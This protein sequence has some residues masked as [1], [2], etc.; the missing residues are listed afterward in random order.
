MDGRSWFDQR[1]Q[2]YRVLEIVGHEEIL[3]VA[4]A[5][6]VVACDQLECFC[7]G[8]WSGNKNRRRGEGAEVG[9]EGRGTE[10]TNGEKRMSE[11]HSA[12][13]LRHLLAAHSPQASSSVETVDKTTVESERDSESEA[14]TFTRS[15]AVS[16]VDCM[17]RQT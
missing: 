2:T 8:V 13:Y 9:M 11:I 3:Q 12:R 17:Y 16:V 6:V 4:L 14:I 7:L 5:I 15:R 10:H 1:V